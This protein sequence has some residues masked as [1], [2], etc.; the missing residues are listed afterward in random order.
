MTVWRDGKSSLPLSPSLTPLWLTFSRLY[1][2]LCYFL[3]HYTTLHHTIHTIPYTPHH[4][5]HTMHTTPCTP[6]HTHHTIHTTPCTLYTPHQGGHD[7]GASSLWS[8]LT[9]HSIVKKVNRLLTPGVVGETV[10]I[11]VE[12]DVIVFVVVV[13][14]VFF[15]LM[16]G[17]LMLLLYCRCLCCCGTQYTNTQRNTQHLEHFEGLEKSLKDVATYVKNA[18]SLLRACLLA[19]KVT[20]WSFELLAWRD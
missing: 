7:G 12:V 1:L 19:L 13:D 15:F 10:V 9:V 8:R 3:H 5:H 11:V 18:T 16:P 4:A 17:L 20:R 2:P 14:V 6:H